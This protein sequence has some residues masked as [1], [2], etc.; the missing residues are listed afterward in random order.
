[1]GGSK[2]LCL[3]SGGG[4]AGT[5]YSDGG[6]A[7]TCCAIRGGGDL[8]GGVVGEEVGAAVGMHAGGAAVAKVVA[9]GF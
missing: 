8:A 9:A 6:V 1:M 7:F 3:I 5:G 4:A 2:V